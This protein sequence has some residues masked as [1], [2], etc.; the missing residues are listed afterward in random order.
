MPSLYQIGLP[1]SIKPSSEE[2]YY[3]V[4]QCII[5]RGQQSLEDAEFISQV[6]EE[7]RPFYGCLFGEDSTPFKESWQ[8]QVL[9]GID[10]DDCETA[11]KTLLLHIKRVGLCPWFGY[12][13]FGG[14]GNFRFVF[15]VD[16]EDTGR[17]E[18]WAH[19]I[20]VLSHLSGTQA[21]HKAIGVRRLW[22]GTNSGT[23]FV[24]KES[25]VTLLTSD[26][27]NFCSKAIR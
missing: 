2:E 6:T 22:Q 17:E 25:K 10:Y 3:S 4:R 7:G 23:L 16:S 19:T 21:D 26:L 8:R 15:K 9:V 20:K 13:T 27:F 18:Q 11:W 14:A 1:R 12:R 24:S 5:D